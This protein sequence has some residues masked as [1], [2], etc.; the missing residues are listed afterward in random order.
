MINYK[1]LFQKSKKRATS[2]IIATIL[3]IG[4]TVVSGAILYG[5]T[6]AFLSTQQNVSLSYE[7]PTVYK[8]ASD[9]YVYSTTKINSFDISVTNPNTQQMMINLASS[10]V[11]YANGTPTT[12]WTADYNSSSYI[13]LNGK[14]S[15]TVTFSTLGSDTFDIGQQYYVVF[16]IMRPDYTGA[17][18][19]TTSTFQ[20]SQADFQPSFQFYPT[21]STINQDNYNVTYYTDSTQTSTLDISG[22]LWNL[23]N[24][25]TSYQKSLQFFTENDTVFTVDPQYTTPNSMAVTIPSSTNVGMGQN[26][27]D[28]CTTGYACVNVSI[29][30][31]KNAV[32]NTQESYGAFLSI[33]GMDLISFQL[34]IRIPTVRI[35]L[36]NT[37]RFNG[38]FFHWRRNQACPT[39]TNLEGQVADTVVFYGSPSCM[40]TKTVTFDIWNLL[41][42]PNNANIEISGLNT[43]A[44][45]LYTSANATGRNSYS[46]MPQSVSLTAGPGVT[47]NRW[48]NFCFNPSRQACN[49]VSWGIARNPLID[50]NGNP[51][52]ILA[53]DYPITVTDTL[54]HTSQQFD[55][56]I[57]PYIVTVH[58]ASMTGSVTSYRHQSILTYKVTVE[59]SDGYTMNNIRVSADYTYPNGHKTKT[60]SESEITFYNGIA[61]FSNFN[62]NSGKNTL[63]VTNLSAYTFRGGFG[64]WQRFTALTVIYDAS[65]NNPNPPSYTVNV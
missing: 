57:Q 4:L 53:G 46:N 36:E 25:D 24:P 45:T 63:L 22:V 50:T 2:P 38:G 19:L 28:V 31:T 58:V 35:T 12:S 34:N 1:K 56:Y 17:T 20:I 43:T 11:Y 47:Y 6:T 30:V 21:F 27:P 14:E 13:I 64:R 48:L 40:D 39:G 32:N 16:S 5:V 7:S 10:K 65:A 62:P 15:T 60:V 23:G 18:T 8:T 61:T 51:T 59:D 52:G 44:F 41:D 54:S 42:T 37:N 9:S 55:L 3:L 33:T 29:P 49:T 26:S